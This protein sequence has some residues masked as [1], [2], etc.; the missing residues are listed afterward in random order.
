M[1]VIY[2]LNT[3][4]TTLER[5]VIT[6][7]NFDG[8]HRGHLALFEKV[9]ER[10]HALH[11][12]SV[13]MTFEPHPI[14]LMK[15]EKPIPLITPIRQKLELIGKAGIEYIFCVPF[16]REFAAITAKDFVLDILVGKIGVKEVV[17][18]YDYTFGRQR[19][20]NVEF[21]EEMGDKWG[22]RLHIIGPIHVDQALVSSTTI[23]GLVQDGRLS[24]AKALLGRDYQ[25]SGTVVR[26]QNRGRRLLGIP[27][28]NLNLIDELIPKRGVYAVTVDID[29]KACNGVT[30]IGY[31]PT[32]G[33]SALTVE[34]HLLDFSEDL[35][36]K[37]IKVNFIQRLRD[38]VSFDSIQDLSDQI[39]RDI[40]QARALLEVYEAE[41]R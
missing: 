23:R 16:T 22:F 1:N 25:I 11:G 9:K 24:E 29:G 15:P 36:G 26:G 30:N 38:E 20:G 12:R 14:R 18:G 19:K 40:Q 5:P 33:D 21:L 31:N 6:I 17:V 32:F 2:D 41:R 8:V 3:L 34:T 28:A 37:T 39:K 35:L 13:L 7:G 10:A 4:E 27:T